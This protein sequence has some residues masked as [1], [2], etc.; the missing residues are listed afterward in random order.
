MERAKLNG[1]LVSFHSVNLRDAFARSMELIDG[2]SERHEGDNSSLANSQTTSVPPP[3][4]IK[5][6]DHTLKLSLHDN[7][8]DSQSLPD[9]NPSDTNLLDVDQDS[10]VRMASSQPSLNVRSQVSH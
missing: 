8:K 2:I 6:H 10:M 5:L 9:T 7:H 1:S 4:A 3:C